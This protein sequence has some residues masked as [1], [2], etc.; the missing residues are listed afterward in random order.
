MGCMTDKIEKR[1]FLRATRAKVWR[2]ISDSKQFGAWFGVAFDEPFVA[3]KPVRGRVTM[4][5]H[6]NLPF[7]MDIVALEPE[8]Y[9]AWRWHPAAIDPNVDYSHEPTT[10]VEF[11]IAD[12]DGGCQLTMRETGLDKIPEARRA[13]VLRMNTAGWDAQAI[14]LEKYLA[15]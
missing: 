8:R 13:T 14:N 6:E 9:L 1:V 11:E 7:A 10:L 12:A 2:A 5:S 15:S 3:G 4:K